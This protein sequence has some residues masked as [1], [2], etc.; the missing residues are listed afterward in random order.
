MFYFLF[1]TIGLSVLLAGQTARGRA[2]V[3]LTIR[4]GTL[5]VMLLVPAWMTTQFRSIQLDH[6]TAV[7]SASV[8]LC[9]TAIGIIPLRRWTWCDTFVALLFVGVLGTQIA[10]GE[11][12]PLTPIELFRRWV[13]PYL[14]GRIFFMRWEDDISRTL[15]WVAGLL[16]LT[17]CL[18]AFEALAKVNIVNKAFGKTFGLLEQGEGYR[19]GMKRSQGPMDHPI[20]NGMMLTLLMPWALEAASRWKAADG[21][22]WWIALPLLLGACLFFTVSRGP[23][24][25]FLA[26]GGIAFFFRFPKLRLLTATIGIVGVL[27][28]FFGKDALMAM[29]KSAAGES[30]E[31][32]RILVIDGQEVEYSGTNHRALLFLV[33]ADAIDQTGWFGY[34]AGLKDVPI[35]EGA[36]DRFGSIDN[37]YIKH[38]LEFGWWGVL[39]F[40]GLAL[41][42]VYYSARL[43]WDARNR[44]AVYAAA[45]CGAL[46]MTS[47]MM[48]S[49]WFSF[50]YGSFWLFSAGT[51]ACLATL[52]PRGMAAYADVD[53]AQPA[54]VAAAPKSAGG[55]R[56]KAP[57]Q[58][59]ES[60]QPKAVAIPA[61]RQP[62][63]NREG[64]S[65]PR[66]ALR[67]RTLRSEETS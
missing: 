18:D 34:G 27:T 22:R 7:L 39:S 67:P 35:A 2:D 64:Q 3:G 50:D 54:T 26:T 13:L 56:L 10:I 25:A 23:Q 63:A 62:A 6:R 59:T 15:P 60:P 11:L 41:S 38:L 14:V 40:V 57:T 20:Y 9:I 65:P 19:W 55:R 43:A 58:R 53:V 31:N 8:L 49:V 66:R 1:L 33:Y 21:R 45:L 17:F 61:A 36:G 32:V 4:R 44:N 52:K 48:M 37:H 47:V 5:A 51:S 30:E 16:A 46:L 12:R 24:I 29:L 42:A 28:V